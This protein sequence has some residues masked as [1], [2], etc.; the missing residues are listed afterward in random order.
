MGNY[1]STET[2]ATNPSNFYTWVPDASNAR[3]EY[4]QYKSK[5]LSPNL[6]KVVDNVHHCGPVLAQ[7]QLGSCTANALAGAYAYRYNIEYNLDASSTDEFLPSRLFIYYNERNAEGTPKTDSG[8]EIR[9]GIASI[10]KNGVCPESMWP[11]DIEKFTDKP[12]TTCY[13]EAAAC[14]K[15]VQQHRVVK[16]LESLKGCLETG[17]VFVFGF[18][19]F[20]SFKDQSKWNGSIMPT[21][22]E[23]EKVLGGHAV[24][25]VGYDDFKQC[26]K[27]RN[28][29]GSDWGED[30]NFYMPYD[31]MIGSF[32]ADKYNLGA[33]YWGKLLKT[34]DNEKA[35]DTDNK[36]DGVQP[37]CSDIWSIDLTFDK[38]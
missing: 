17:R 22:Q 30:G 27:V 24:L 5:M 3:D 26:F 33:T 31:F 10:E 25:C 34:S 38:A 12:P 16:N 9:D 2:S 4:R 20:E 32:N 35:D 36:Q 18:V 14:H 28:S 21:P 1:F 19:V 37:L 23:G 7:G 15:S 29:W 11:Y 8:A 6:K 13:D